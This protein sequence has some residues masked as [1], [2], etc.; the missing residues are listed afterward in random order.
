MAFED[1][2]ARGLP[3]EPQRVEGALTKELVPRLTERERKAFMG[4][5]TPPGSGWYD[6]ERIELNAFTSP[7]FIAFLEEKL[8]EHGAD[9]K[10]VPPIEML[11]TTAR[12]TIQPE[13][14]TIVRD[15]IVRRLDVNGIVDRVLASAHL[16]SVEDE[17]TAVSPDDLVTLLTRD[18]IRPWEWALNEHIASIV[19][20]ERDAIDAAIDVALPKSA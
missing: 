10:L 7:Q 20:A 11:Q 18:R 1:G 15:E 19:E 5:E 13:L 14:H 2:I 17:A 3:I 9:V 12:Q 8:A 4:T 16:R 6:C